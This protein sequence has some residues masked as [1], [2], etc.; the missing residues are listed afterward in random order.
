MKNWFWTPKR[1]PD[2]GCAVRPIGHLAGKQPFEIQAE[3]PMAPVRSRAERPVAKFSWLADH[4][5]VT[6]ALAIP[7]A[8]LQ[9]P[10]LGLRH[11]PV[12]KLRRVPAGGASACVSHQVAQGRATSR[13][14]RAVA[15]CS[16]AGAVQSDHPARSRPRLPRGRTRT[17]CHRGIRAGCRQQPALH[18][19][20]FP[21]GN[22]L[23]EGG[24]YRRGNRCVRPRY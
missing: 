19:C 23:G 5:R 8:T 3:G 24:R 21:P 18:R 12:S 4:G 1:P 15:R 20:T 16:V 22:R 17:R 10:T 6:I 9:L 14:D 13:C 7:M 11:V 2:R